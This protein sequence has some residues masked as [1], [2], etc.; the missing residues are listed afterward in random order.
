[1]ANELVTW[2]DDFLVG[3]SII[4]AQHRELVNITNEFYAGVKMGG[5]VAKAYFLQ[6]IKGA[7]N[8]VRTHFQEEEA[9]M[10]KIEYPQ[11][12]AHKKQHEN[13]VAE[14]TQQIKTFE[15]EDNPNPAG[16][17][18]YLMDWILNHIAQSDKKYTPYLSKLK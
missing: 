16:F 11:Y 2:S 10:R 4:D 5:L 9:L 1:M 12:E 15:K 3:N 13:F 6:T 14:V 8:Y 7:V 17:V 18:K